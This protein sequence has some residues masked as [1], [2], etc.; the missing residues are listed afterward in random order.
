MILEKGRE[1]SRSELVRGRRRDWV[2]HLMLALHQAHR[3]LDIYLILILIYSTTVYCRTP[4]GSTA[5]RITNNQ[6]SELEVPVPIDAIQKTGLKKFCTLTVSIWESKNV[7]TKKEKEI[8]WNVYLE[9]KFSRWKNWFWTK[10]WLT[11]LLASCMSL[12]AYG[13][14]GLLGC[15]M[16]DARVNSRLWVSVW[17][18]D[19]RRAGETVLGR[20][21]PPGLSTVSVWRLGWKTPTRRPAARR[22]VSRTGLSK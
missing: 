21:S 15:W 20:G 4:R 7:E 2:I 19:Q 1:L 17:T 13:L 22:C 6:I 10:F 8:R 12:F 5:R 3:S 11:S 16:L 14:A 9:T 18:D